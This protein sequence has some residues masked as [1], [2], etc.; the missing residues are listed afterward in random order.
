MQRTTNHRM[1]EAGKDFWR[2]PDH[3]LCS[4]QDQLEQANQGSA[5]EHVQEG[6]VCSLSGL[7]VLDHSPGG[8]EMSSYLV[9][10][11]WCNIQ[12]LTLSI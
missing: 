11:S 12:P 5:S 6:R 4:E 8:K 7:P 2:P 1:A 3:L 9:D 10:M